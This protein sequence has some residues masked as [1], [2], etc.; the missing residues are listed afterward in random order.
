[1]GFYVV[2]PTSTTRCK[3]NVIR[4]NRIGS[5]TDSL[6]TYGIQVTHSENSIIENNIIQNLKVTISGADQL[7]AGIVSVVG[8]NDI[9]RSNVISNLRG[10]S[11]FTTSGIALYGIAGGQGNNSYVYNNM[12]YDIHSVSTQTNSRVAG[13][14]V[15]YQNN[16][17]IYYN[18]VYLS[19]TGE[20]QLGSAALYIFSNVTNADVKNNIFVNTRD[21][22]PYCGSAIYDYGSANLT[23]DY[24]DLYYD[25]TNN[26]NCLVRIGSTD[27]HTLADWQATGKDLHSYVEMPHFISPTDL[28]I[29][30]GTATYLESRGTPIAEVLTDIDGDVRD[31]DSTDIGADE[32]DGI[33]GVENEETLPTE[34]AL[35]QNYPNPFNPNTTF[36]YSIP[37]QSKVV[38]KLFD[39]LGNEIATLLDEEKS[40]GTYELMWNAQNLSSGIYFYQ[41]KAGEFTQT[42]KM[43]LL[44]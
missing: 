18:S 24:N 17:K 10:I 16:P 38:I 13:I 42:R 31:N 34:F 21:E 29:D 33:V 41:L 35:E 26:N 39:I 37:K 32:F 3:G 15:Q 9:I 36:R 2:S 7:T 25:N 4:G 14:Q 44:K 27:Y 6:I 43:L 19:G 8:S 20:I 28:H 40:V 22:S 5:E 30:E 11:G 1:M 23:S 12:I